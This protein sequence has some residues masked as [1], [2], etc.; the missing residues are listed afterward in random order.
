MPGSKI[1]TTPTPTGPTASSAR[2][3]SRRSALVIA[4][5]GVAVITGLFFA[6]TRGDEHP[7]PQAAGGVQ[8]GHIHGIGVDPGDGQ[9]YVGAHLGT[10]RVT[11][12]GTVTPV[13]A[14]RNDTMAFTVAGPGRFLAS[15]H[16]EVGTD[17]PVHLGLIESRDAATTWE[18]MSLAGDADFHALD[19][20]TGGRTWGVDSARGLLLTSTDNRAWDTV[21]TGQ[22]IDLAA[23][24]TGQDV[25][26]VTTGT[27]Q[28]RFY[29]PEGATTAV[30]DSP[31]LT[32]IDWASPDLVDGLGPDGTVFT[33]TGTASEWQRAG[34]VPGQPSALEVSDAGWYAASDQGL[35][36]SASSGTTWKPVFTYGTAP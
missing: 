13:G 4:A 22:F 7:A 21:A 20:S 12:Q 5:L 14:V 8:V 23:A 3:P 35:F 33:S 19:V 24:P 27:G 29:A 11:P 2:F 9:L 1:D 26:L 18:A 34:R 15:G 25:A 10:F 30:P 16:P 17:Q 31:V 6:V 32:F 28:L 36:S